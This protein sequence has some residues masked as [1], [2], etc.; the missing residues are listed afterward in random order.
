L[1]SQRIPPQRKCPWEKFM[2]E[3]CSEKLLTRAATI[4]KQNSVRDATVANESTLVL[5]AVI[6]APRNSF[7]HRRSPP[8]HFQKKFTGASAGAR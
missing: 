3:G 1:N 7:S 8:F 4:R 6:I 5:T 2:S